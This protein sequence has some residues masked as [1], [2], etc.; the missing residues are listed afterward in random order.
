VEFNMMPESPITCEELLKSV[1]LGLLWT[2]DGPT[3]DFFDLDEAV[4]DRYDAVVL[5]AARAIWDGD[6]E[7][8]V[9]QRLGLLQKRPPTSGDW[10]TSS[11]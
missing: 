6:L 11:K 8:R 9:A 10:S 2:D 1:G 7:P 5:S 4:L 3:A